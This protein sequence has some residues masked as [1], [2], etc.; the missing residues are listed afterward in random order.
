MSPMLRPHRR[1]TNDLLAYLMNRPDD[2]TQMTFKKT[3]RTDN[4]ICID[5]FNPYHP[6]AIYL[7]RNKNKCFT[8]LF[9]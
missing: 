5:P 4:T 9:Q 7:L 2:G 6:C 1:R 8:Q 3:I